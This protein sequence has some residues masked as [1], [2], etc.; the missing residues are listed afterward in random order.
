VVV[1]R[2]LGYKAAARTRNAPHER[3]RH[4][5]DSKCSR[6]SRCGSTIHRRVFE[7]FGSSRMILDSLKFTAENARELRLRMDLTLGSGW[8]FGGPRIP[9]TQAGGR[10]S[11]AVTCA[12]RDG[13][14]LIAAFDGVRHVELTQIA[15]TEVRLPSGPDRPTDCGSSFRAAPA[16]C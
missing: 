2:A 9:I 1:V 13:E 4:S 12:M 6:S 15:G 3:G 10:G 7:T 16:G 11:A 5:A 14:K 8:P